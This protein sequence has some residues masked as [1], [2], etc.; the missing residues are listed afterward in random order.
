MRIEYGTIRRDIPAELLG[1]HV[2]ADILD[3]S[4]ED[5]HYYAAREHGAEVL[6]GPPAL[7]KEWTGEN[8]VTHNDCVVLVW[9]MARFYF[10]IDEVTTD[11]NTRTD[12]HHRV[13]LMDR[14]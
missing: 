13:A 3:H 8:Y 12:T 2:W 4:Q 14:C 5:V 1:T 10:S 9:P 7:A 6:I 11:A